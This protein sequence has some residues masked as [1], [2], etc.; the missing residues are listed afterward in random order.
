MVFGGILRDSA[1]KMAVTPFCVFSIIK[2]FYSDY[3]KSINYWHYWS[4]R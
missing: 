2:H 3:A 4:G 1:G